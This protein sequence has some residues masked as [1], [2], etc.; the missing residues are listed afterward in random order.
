MNYLNLGCG[1]H[2]H[3]N[4]TN[5]DFVSTGE[6]VLAHNLRTGIPFDDCTFDVV[7]HSHVLEHFPKDE[8]PYFLYECLRVLKPEGVL[9]LVVPDLEQIARCYLKALEH[10]LAGSQE[11][12]QNYNWILLELYDQV[13][14]NVSGGDMAAYLAQETIANEDFVIQR[15]GHEAENL[16]R[17][18]RARKSRLEESHSFAAL[19]ESE[20]LLLDLLGSEDYQALQIGRFRKSGEVHQWMYDRYSIKVLLEDRGFQNISICSASE[21]SIPN[22]VSFCLDTLPDGRTRKPDSLFMEAIKPAHANPKSIQLTSKTTLNSHQPPKVLDE[23]PAVQS[24]NEKISTLK[25][26]V[27]NRKEENQRL[28][29]ELK[30]QQMELEAIKNSKLWKLRGFVNR[31]KQVLGLVD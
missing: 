28:T 25:K 29:E 31:A 27:K 17:I 12:A 14:R 4:W 30:A 20:S 13:V 11:W 10:S 24:L 23:L 21:S 8:A 26:R 9:R 2:F 19:S 15:T 6:G 22:F 18:L 16:I 1:S 5:V 7:Y 3:P